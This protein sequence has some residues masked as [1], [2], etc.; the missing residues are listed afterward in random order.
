MTAVRLG[1]PFTVRSGGRHAGAAEVRRARLQG[2]PAD[3]QPLLPAEGGVHLPLRRQ[4]AGRRRPARPQPRQRARPARAQAGG[5]HRRPGRLRQRLPRRAEAGGDPGLLR[6]G[7]PRER[8]VHGRV[9]DLVHARQARQDR[10][11]LARELVAGGRRR[12]QAGLHHAGPAEGRLR[13][14]PGAP[15]RRGPRLGQDH[16]GRPDAERPGQGLPPRRA[17]ARVQPARADGVRLQVVRPRRRHGARA[18]VRRRQ[19]GR[20]QPLRR[21]HAERRRRRGRRARPGRAR[22]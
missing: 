12:R 10:Q 20:G 21:D 18:G 14:L 17:D 9:R 5:R 1:V 13:L 11:G 15:A 7:R 6:P 4:G 16:G 8:L 2:R 19:A 22:P 3:R